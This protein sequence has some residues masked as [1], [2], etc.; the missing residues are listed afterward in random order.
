MVGAASVEVD[1]VEAAFAAVEGAVEA[2]YRLSRSH[3]DRVGT[4][5]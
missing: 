2:A 5:S 3:G 4:Q 1:S